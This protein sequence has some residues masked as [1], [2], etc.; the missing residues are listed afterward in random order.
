MFIP[1]PSSSMPDDWDEEED[2]DWEPVLVS[3]K[4]AEV[5]TLL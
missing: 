1:N 2:G 4:T 3:A 5:V